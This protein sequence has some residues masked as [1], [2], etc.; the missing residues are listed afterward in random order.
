MSYYPNLGIS[1][2]SGS[3]RRQHLKQAL[4]GLS[5][6]GIQCVSSPPGHIDAYAAGGG[7]GYTWDETP[8]DQACIG[9]S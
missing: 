9:P 5:V 2:T 1:M 3:V 6:S 4:A 7:Q 8:V